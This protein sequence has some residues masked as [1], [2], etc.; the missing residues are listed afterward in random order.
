MA[1]ANAVVSLWLSACVDHCAMHPDEALSARGLGCRAD[2]ANPMEAAS[3]GRAGERPPA[4]S[5]EEGTAT[6]AKRSCAQASGI[7]PAGRVQLARQRMLFAPPSRCRGSLRETVA[8]NPGELEQ[9][10]SPGEEFG[11]RISHV[12]RQ[13][14]DTAFDR[15]KARDA[16]I[17]SVVSECLLLAATTAHG[18]RTDDHDFIGMVSGLAAREAFLRKAAAVYDE[19]GRASGRAEAP[20]AGRTAPMH[21]MPPDSGQGEVHAVACAKEPALGA[22]PAPIEL[23]GPPKPA[24]AAAQASSAEGLEIESV[25]WPERSIPNTGA[26]QSCEIRPPGRDARIVGNDGGDGHIGLLVIVLLG[27]LGLGWLGVSS[28]NRLIGTEGPQWARSA[29][30]NAVVERIIQAESN[31]DA[32]AKNKRSSATGPA[33]FLD[34]TWLEMI[35][36]Y[37]PDVARGR[38]EKEILELR[39]DP[40]L[41]H[42]ITIRFVERNAAALSKHGLP[43]TP[44][45][46]YLSHFAGPA[47]AIAILSVPDNTDAADLMAR[48]DATGR[49]TREKLINANPFLATFTVAD[50]KRWADR[51]M[52]LR[53]LR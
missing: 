10:L 17:A 31:G 11:K 53:Q 39:R 52:E 40:D 20:S 14:I 5:A 49:T 4:W 24:M 21:A 30:V 29:A 19:I 37:R 35:R 38:T 16:T 1:A 34:E 43:V 13:A 27:A 36:A 41:A 25:V 22:A 32:N 23:T 12:C 50:L 9:V 2:L 44:G 15:S 42:E 47:G 7:E 3:V 33:Q 28:L 45:T 48:A 26:A 46:L 51:K 18:E 6:G 8:R